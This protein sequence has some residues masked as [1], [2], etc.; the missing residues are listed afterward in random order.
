[1][2]KINK[3]FRDEDTLYTVSEEM[4]DCINRVLEF[5]N[6]GACFTNTP[7]P[8]C[9]VLST[10]ADD[11]T[12]IYSLEFSGLPN[13]DYRKSVPLEKMEFNY[14]VDKIMWGLKVYMLE[15]ADYLIKTEML[16]K[17]EDYNG[18]L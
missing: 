15:Y 10:H 4:T 16:V 9:S 17:M 18:I 13:W 8:F 12:K 5:K 11:G 7:I 14:V 6:Y 2:S 3:I 1:M